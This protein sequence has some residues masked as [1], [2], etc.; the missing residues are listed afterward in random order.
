[1]V[2]VVDSG[3]DA[4]VPELADHVT[5]G[6]D[7]VTGTGRGDTDCL[8]TG[9]A[10]A[11]IV[12]ARSD[13]SSGMH[14]MAPDAMVMPVRVAPT[15][16][17]VSE[18]DQAS[19]IEVAVSA[20]AEVIA[21]GAFVDPSK[22]AVSSAIEYAAGH[23]VVIVAGAPVRSGEGSAASGPGPMQ[24]AGFVRVGAIGIGGEVAAGYQPGA[25]DVV[26]PG[27]DVV[28]LGISGVGPFQATGTQYAVAFVAGQ[29]AL[30]RSMYPNLSAAQVVRRIEATADR[31]GSDPPDATYGWGLI[32]PGEAITRVIADENGRPDPAE[33]GSGTWSSLR[34]WALIIIVLL[35][36]V[37]VLLLVLRIRRLVRAAPLAAED[38]A[39][40]SAHE[41]VG[42][43]PWVDDRATTEVALPTTESALAEP[44]KARVSADRAE[45]LRPAAHAGAWSA[46]EP[47]REEEVRRRR[48]DAGA[49]WW[50]HGPDG[51]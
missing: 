11:G 43:T 29:A 34:T 50:R 17:A 26:A 15:A 33:A 14:G 24:A 28:G 38:T 10:M 2:A 8:G 25:V 30:V 6:V 9:T 1:M 5:I 20:G 12:A 36:L 16:A 39:E 42:A 51:S 13:A 7:I 45:A 41:M 35:A 18:S 49:D 37:M 31:M 21:L 19:A 47:G 44:A 46:G 27:V 22:P 4:A 32:N 48:T 3:V 40:E 23:D